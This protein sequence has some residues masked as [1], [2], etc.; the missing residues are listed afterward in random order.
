MKYFLGFIGKLF[1]MADLY[2]LLTYALPYFKTVP[3][4]LYVNQTLFESSKPDLSTLERFGYRPL[5]QIKGM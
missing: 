1:K 2:G 3:I 4:G 5:S